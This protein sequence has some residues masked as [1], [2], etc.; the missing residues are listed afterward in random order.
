MRLRFLAALLATAIAVTGAYSV[1]RQT[2]GLHE[3]AL[4]VEI[5]PHV[6]VTAVARY[7][8]AEGAVRSAWMAAVVATLRGS[9][10][11]LKAGEYEFPR[12]ASTIDVV[13]MVES[14]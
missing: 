1:I 10:R 13:R 12:G 4:V 5:P 11:R 3:R 8:E 14:G 6:G 9:A 7:L 2:P